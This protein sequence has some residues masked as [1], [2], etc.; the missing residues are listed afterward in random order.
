LRN[1]FPT[2]TTL[3]N[4]MTEALAATAPAGVLAAAAGD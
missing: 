4:L 2:R 3:D 1:M